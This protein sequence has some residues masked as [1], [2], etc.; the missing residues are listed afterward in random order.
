ME[1][2]M[3]KK[4]FL[5]LVVSMFFSFPVLAHDFWAGVEKATV[6]EPALV[7][8]GYG[9]GFPAAEE[10]LPDVYSER[11]EPVTLI[12]PKGEIKL[13]KGAKA[14]DFI[15][16]EPLTAGSYYLLTSS[17]ASFFSRSPS[18]FVRKSKAEDTTATACSYGANYGKNLINLAPVGDD[19]FVTKPT[20]QKLEIVPQ[21]NPEKVKP[22]DKFPVKVFFSGKPLARASVGAFFDGF[23]ENNQ[24]L[25]F[26]S[27][28]NEDGLVDIIVLR[29][30]NW[31][32]KVSQSGPYSDLNVCDKETYSASFAFTIS[33]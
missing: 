32:A 4:C 30:G 25:A 12:G 27:S 31:L 26:S 20:G 9:H 16:A 21:I 5:L 33:E 18:G 11:F 6:G 10:I 14:Q 19:S 3:L 17:K 13:N 23:S 7:F 15:S 24:A 29:P 22:G 28:T 2:K 1:F 8:L